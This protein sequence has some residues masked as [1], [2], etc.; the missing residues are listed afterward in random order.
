M[1]ELLEKIATANA[2]FLAESTAFAEKGNKAAGQ[3]ARKAS[4]ELTKLYKEFRAL[5]NAE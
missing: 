1:K 4:N 2:T 5:S 3:R